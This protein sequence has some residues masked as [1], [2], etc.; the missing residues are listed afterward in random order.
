MF[1]SL[2]TYLKYR[3]VFDPEDE[4]VL[5][6]DDDVEEEDGLSRDRLPGDQHQE[7]NRNR[8]RTEAEP[9][10]DFVC[11]DHRW[12]HTG[13]KYRRVEVLLA[14]ESPIYISRFIAFL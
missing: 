2:F 9:V 8:K 11:Q 1:N 4:E 7:A 5:D 6:D 14:E 12:M 13:G 10:K 3:R